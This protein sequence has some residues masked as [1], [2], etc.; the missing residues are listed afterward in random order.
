VHDV[1]FLLRAGPTWRGGGGRLLPPAPASPAPCCPLCCG[2]PHDHPTLCLVRCMAFGGGRGWQAV[3]SGGERELLQQWL[4][5]TRRLGCAC[6]FAVCPGLG[7]T[8][9]ALQRWRCLF[10]LCWRPWRRVGTLS[11]G[12]RPPRGPT[13]VVVL[14]RRAGPAFQAHLS[15][16][17]VRTERRPRGSGGGGRRG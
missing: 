8:A 11:A 14:P 3:G 5:V 1:L 9:A 17:K 12:C 15:P 13:H 7:T 16:R 2:L 6:L 10:C 4:F